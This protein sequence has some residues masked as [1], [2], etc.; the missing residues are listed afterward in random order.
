VRASRGIVALVASA[1]SLATIGASTP[2]SATVTHTLIEGSGSSWA[3]NAV[4]QWI[5]DVQPSG[6]QVVYTPDGSAAGKQDFADQVSDFAVT[7]VPYLGRDPETGTVDSS[8]GR[9][10]GTI[11]ISAGATTFPYH[12]TIDGKLV[13]NLRLSPLTV[14]KIFTDQITNWDDPAITADNNGV[15]LPSLK[16]IPVV[17]SE[18]SGVSYD[19]TTY[20]ADRYPKLWKA[21]S[22]I[23]GPTQYY[24]TAGNQTAENGSDATMNYITSSSA[25]GAIG[26][27]EYS[28]A[29]AVNYPVADIEN[30][31]GYF[32]APVEYNVAI[33]LRSATIDENP[34]DAHYMRPNL[35]PVFASTDRRAYPLSF[36]SSMLVPTSAT[37]AKMTTA[38]RQTLADFAYY[39][40]CQGQAE[41]G[42]I[43]FAPLPLNLV[44]AGF[45]QIHRLHAADPLVD[46]TDE[47]V[48]TCHNPTFIS[49]DLK[50]DYLGEL[51]PEPQACDKR[52]Q[53]PCAVR[54][55]ARLTASRSTVKSGNTVV[56][57]GRLYYHPQ[58]GG[59]P[60]A[61]VYLQ[62]RLPHHGWKTIA[63]TK[64]AMTGTVTVRL[65]VTATADY[66]LVDAEPASGRPTSPVVRVSV[67]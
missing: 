17:Q 59:P 49:G 33:A 64:T 4:D 21:F 52:G 27:V 58:A 55:V 57:H 1:A 2:A 32:V 35:K 34:A 42:P 10:Y 51:A 31:A 39:A 62:R 22:G 12:L 53:G 38:K 60:R 67:S 44:K 43:G 15:T 65:A 37:D 24:P 8:K 18:G 6:L 23:S 5:A 50:R 29:L 66:R 46:E 20:L 14:A 48:S 7:D 30:A 25:D 36:Y 61:L 41:V 19:F 16:I 45:T 63:K 9:E 56:F 47:T 13:R 26:I 54:T 11:P 28:Y 40:I 3:S